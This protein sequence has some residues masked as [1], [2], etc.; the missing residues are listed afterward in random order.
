L[1]LKHAFQFTYFP[2]LLRL[3]QMEDARQVLTLYNLVFPRE[4]VRM[5]AMV[6]LLAG[7]TFFV[8][9]RAKGGGHGE[10]NASGHRG[11]SVTGGHVNNCNHSVRG[12]TKRDGTH[13][14][15]SHATN[16]DDGKSD[17]DTHQGS[18]NPYT[19]KEGSKK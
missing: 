4:E 1:L 6:F 15:P 11:R 10:V 3:L 16:A 8:N 7:C 5:K 13:V 9:V 2:S 19:S 14:E 12:H 17:N 18:T